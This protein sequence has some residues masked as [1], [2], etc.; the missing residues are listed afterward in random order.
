MPRRLSCLVVFCV[1]ATVLVGPAF[2]APSI[3]LVTA[4]TSAALYDKFEATF[5]VST[6][7]TNPYW[8]YDPSPAANTDS[9]PSAV[10]AGVGVSVDCLLSADDW[11]TT[12]VQPAFYVLPLATAIN[13]ATG[14]LRVMGNKRAWLYPSG[15]PVWMVRFAP[16]A[17]GTWRF[18]LRVTDSSGQTIGPESTFNCAAGSNKGFVRVSQTD[19][20]YFE[21]SDGS[22]LPLVGVYEGPD[23][24]TMDSVLSTYKDMGIN[25]VRSWW[26]NSGTVVPLFGSS[27][28]GGDGYWSNL[29]YSTSYLPAGRLVVARVPNNT[30][31]PS[32]GLNTTVSVKPSTNYRLVARLKAVGVTGDGDYGLWVARDW[33]TGTTKLKGDVDWTDVTLDFTTAANAY[34]TRLSAGLFN[35]TGGNGY[36]SR[37]SLRERLPGGALGPELVGRPGFEPHSDFNQLVAAVG[38]VMLDTL[39]SYGIYLKLVAQEKQDQFYGSIRADGTWGSYDVENFYAWPEHAS[40]V[41]QQYYW[42]YL[43]ARYGYSTTIHS[44]EFANECDPVSPSHYNAA[45]A[46]AEFVASVDLNHHLVTTS[47]WHSFPPHLWQRPSMGYADL[48]MYLGVIAP[49]VTRT[50]PGWDG[51]WTRNEANALAEGFEINTTAKH[52]GRRSLKMTIPPADQYSPRYAGISFECGLLTGHQ[53]RVSAW[54]KGENVKIFSSSTSPGCLLQFRDNHG[55]D[56][57]G[58]PSCGDLRAPTGTYDWQLVERVFTVPETTTV[59]N[60]PQNVTPHLLEIMPRHFCNND[61][62]PGYL[63]FDDLVVEDLTTGLRLNY[64]GGFEDI[65]PEAYDIVAGH[66]AH[67]TLTRSCQLGKPVIK[68]ELGLVNPQRFATPYKGFGYTG[69][70]QLLVDDTDGL[71]WKKLVW[72]HVEPGGQTD[73]WWWIQTL[74]PRKFTYGKAYRAFMAGIP[75]SNGRY[76][77]LDA[78]SS[79]PDLR[80]LGQKD[81]TANRA[82]IWFDN[83][84]YTWKAVVD[85]NYSPEPWSS[86]ATYAKDSTCGGGSPV[87]IYKSLQANNKNH[88]VTDTAWWV[89]TGEFK[90]T[91][92]PPL[93]PPVSGTVTVSGLRDGAYK[94][95][96]SDTG[97][98]V[99]TA[100]Q[101]L[102]CTDGDIVLTVQNLVSD[103]AC[104]IYPAPPKLD[105]MVLVPA[106]E[107]VPGQEVT[108]TVEYTNTGD[109]EAKDAIVT[110]RVPAAMDYVAGSAEASG[111][112]YDAATGHVSW[113]V[114]SVG[115]GQTGTRTFRAKVR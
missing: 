40:R 76:Q 100:S 91:G 96:W 115:A 12:I 22:Y 53:I 50:W 88:P 68:G 111:G 113:T 3:E 24:E 92:N 90:A 81:L 72:S 93:P 27:G 54:L 14:K 86:T 52:S 36:C 106:T 73:M 10:P 15:P 55:G 18:K 82:H 39:S 108:V 103:V 99:I 29:M 70:D 84:P 43:L 49:G 104:K 58:S 4:P 37:I 44:L 85:H 35:A 105:L 94:A 77:D 28:Q 38:D 61:T 11:Q 65:T 109:S 46:F 64:N 112:S 75:L 2:G 31:G 102:T 21:L 98:G 7:A 114:D 17:T 66:V 32:V 20:R 25:L 5:R 23:V 45:Q 74:L 59:G 71:C 63:W 26:Q 60:P 42:R 51:S 83:A 80:V 107:V 62:Q 95:E 87:H 33:P 8:P 79:T 101:D 19:S 48:H 47:N 13:P 41:Y 110:A 34:E 56:S 97:T 67:S 6:V 1:A 57:A 78:T 89:D 16:T 9:H 69:E 30:A